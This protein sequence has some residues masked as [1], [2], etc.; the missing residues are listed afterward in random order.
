MSKRKSEGF[1]LSCISLPWHSHPLVLF[2]GLL[3]L[4]LL[5]GWDK[6]HA[7]LHGG[8]GSSQKWEEWLQHTWSLLSNL[9]LGLLLHLLLHAIHSRDAAE[10]AGYGNCGKAGCVEIKLEPVY[11]LEQPRAQP[12]AEAG[13]VTPAVAAG[14]LYASPAEI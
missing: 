14:P 2:N 7:G 6:A 9:F 10:H 13:A 5:V 11:L 1:V 3:C 12:R 4:L 8:N